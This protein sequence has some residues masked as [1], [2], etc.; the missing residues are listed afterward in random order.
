M[1]SA[2]YNH[3]YRCHEVANN[4]TVVPFKLTTFNSSQLDIE[5][6]PDLAFQKFTVS[7]NTYVIPVIIILGL[8]GNTLS[9]S[10][11]VGTHLNR[12]SSSVYLAFLAAVDNAFLITLLLVWFG[13]VEIHIF[14]R[15]GW[16]Q[17]II[18]GTYVC[19]FLSVWTVLFFT[20]DR[21]IVVF[22]PLRRQ[23]MCTRRRAVL[24]MSML[25]SAALLFYSFTFKTFGVVYMNDV[26][27]CRQLQ[28]RYLGVH[29][30][31]TSVDTLIG[32]LL[33]TVATVA[34]NTAIGV[35]VYN[36]TRRTVE[37]ND[38]DFVSDAYSSSVVPKIRHMVVEVDSDSSRHYHACRAVS[39]ATSGRL[40]A[41]RPHRTI[42]SCARRQRSQ[43]RVTRALLVVSTVFI[44]LN[45][46]SHSFRILAFVLSFIK[47][48]IPL[49]AYT[50]LELLQ[51]LYYLS[52][53]SNFILYMMLSKNFRNA[54]RRLV[55]RT[56]YTIR[57]SMCPEI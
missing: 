14:K 31:L 55:H 27:I 30:A 10:V 28:E 5:F 26:P 19:S 46:P 54:I 6:N 21:F 12:Q 49:T 20:V 1:G 39:S 52:F 8:I 13:W 22:F 18:Y 53:S 35:K 44:L 47:D 9:F 16:C 15:E 56:R 38:T 41:V 29:I 11:F 3:M 25:T 36:Y 43:M 33:P 48:T 42:Q 45:L 23:R 50:W 24:S 32:V 37:K 4:S 7:L 34:M 51:F 2:D 17:T 40:A 57:A